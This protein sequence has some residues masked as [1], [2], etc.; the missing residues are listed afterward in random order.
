MSLDSSA[1]SPTDPSLDAALAGDGELLALQQG[2]ERHFV[3]AIEATPMRSEPFPHVFIEG[4][5]PQ[6]VYDELIANLPDDDFYEPLIHKDSVRPDGT[7]PRIQASLTESRLAMLPE[8]RSRMLWTAT[9]RAVQADSI[10][11]ALLRKLEPGIRERHDEPLEEIEA[12]C[13]PALNRDV[14]GY[15]I[16]P[17]PDTKAKVLTGLIYLP[18]DASQ[19]GLGT[20]FYVPKRRFPGLKPKYALSATMPFQ[21]N[22]CLVFAVTK[23]SF[24]GREPLPENCGIRD[25]FAL[26]YYN[27]PTR[28]GYE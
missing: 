5:L 11:L 25:Y 20:S 28:R 6:D 22:A 15:K 9:A 27:D 8:G 14:A 3:A 2:I 26:T 24:H 21:A 10:K 23:R 16:L 7:S 18:R 12:Y 17:H 4:C 1:S 19:V 13:R